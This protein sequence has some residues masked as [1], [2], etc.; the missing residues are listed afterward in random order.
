MAEVRGNLAGLL[1]LEE[2]V[3]GSVGAGRGTRL[4]PQCSV[5]VSW[6]PPANLR[7]RFRLGI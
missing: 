7:K 6:L 3:F 4:L 5:Q 2:S 1:R